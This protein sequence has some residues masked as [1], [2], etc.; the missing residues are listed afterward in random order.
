MSI[1]FPSI[2]P[3][4]RPTPSDAV[5]HDVPHA[6]L[7]EP[8]ENGPV[9]ETTLT[10]EIN[11]EEAARSLNDLLKPVN[12]SL[13]FHRDAATNRIVVEVIDLRSGQ[14]LRQFPNEA[15]LHLAAVLGRLQGHVIDQR[16]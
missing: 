10:S 1:E 4:S 11:L 16:A 5:R 8:F 15:I 14:Q 2:P 6:A 12:T 13:Q 3:I 7:Y 9:E